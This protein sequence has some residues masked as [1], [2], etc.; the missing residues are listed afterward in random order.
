MAD[1]T[2]PIEL[3]LEDQRSEEVRRNHGQCLRELQNAPGARCVIVE[4][5][6]L[7]DGVATIV[8]H[9]LG[10]T[11]RFVST[12]VIRGA[13]STGRI[14]ESYEGIDRRKVVKLTANGHGATIKVSVKVEA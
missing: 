6:S 2:P 5:V 3:R 11:P 14:V 10:R 8:A 13:T 1:F 12:S 7:A 4:D 9:G